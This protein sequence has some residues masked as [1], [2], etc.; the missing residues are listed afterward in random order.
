MIIETVDV[1]LQIF[2][3]STLEQLEKTIKASNN[4]NTRR[5]TIID[6]RNVLKEE[7][8][9][10]E[11]VDMKPEFAKALEKCVEFSDKYIYF[12]S[13]L[14]SKGKSA[15]MLRGDLKRK[16]SKQ[17]LEEV[18]EE[19]KKLNEDKQTFLKEYKQMKEERAAM[20]LNLEAG[21]HALEVVHNLL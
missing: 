9:H 18:K 2:N 4:A 12:W 7:K 21:S 13:G 6:P 8:N 16:G 1:L 3:P 17:E 10:N 20:N 19:E 5:I 14:G 11:M 15:Y